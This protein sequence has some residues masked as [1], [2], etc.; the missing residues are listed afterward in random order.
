[1]TQVEID[2]AVASITGESAAEI[3]RRGFSIADPL[4]VRFDPEPR[5]PLVYDW[6]TRSPIDWPG[7]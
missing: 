1:M 7:V 3:H 5:R 6:D 4:E 2:K